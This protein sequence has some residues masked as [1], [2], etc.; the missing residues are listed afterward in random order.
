MSLKPIDLQSLFAKLSE[1]GKEQSLLKEHTAAQQAHV[2]QTQIRKELEEDRR[3]L[4]TAQDS[5]TETIRDDKEQ[6]EGRGWKQSGNDARHEDGGEVSTV[7]VTDPEVG[8][9]IDLIG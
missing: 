6:Q 9:H 2:A 4:E 1:V 3:V 7:I 5:E 8:R